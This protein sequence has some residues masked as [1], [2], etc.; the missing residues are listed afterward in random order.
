MFTPQPAAGRAA[1]SPHLTLPPPDP[2]RRR[3]PIPWL[4]SLAPVLGAFVLWQVTGYAGVLWFAL[5]GP[6]IAV[7]GVLDGSRAGRRAAREQQRVRAALALRIREEIDRRHAVERSEAS[8][9]TP[10]LDGYLDEPGELWRPH[11]SRGGLLVVG[12][13]DVVS[14]VRVNAADDELSRELITRA[15]TVSDAPVTVPLGA[16]IAV[17]GP[18]VIAAAVARGLV[19]QLCCT[20]P[21]GSLRVVT[22]AADAWVAALPHRAGSGVPCHL[23]LDAAQVRGREDAAVIV[24]EPHEPV[25]TRCA[26]VLTLDDIHRA[27]LEYAGRAVDVCVDVLSAAQAVRLASA[28]GERYRA[29]PGRR[30]LPSDVAARE[31]EHPT[32]GVGLAVAIGADGNGPAIVDLVADGPHALVAGMT[33]SGKSELLVTWVAQLAATRSTREVTFLL[34]DFKGGTAFD[35]LAELPHVAGVLTDLD[36][37]ATQRALESLRAEIRHRERALAA[38]GARDVADAGVEL[39]RLVVV[40]DEFAALLEAHRELGTLFADLAARGRALGIHLILGTQRAAGVV[41]ESLLANCPLRVSLRVVDD[42]DSRFV[43]GTH[44]AAEIPGELASRGTAFVRRAGDAE[45]HAL[46]VARTTPADVATIC[47]RRRAEPAPRRPWQPPLPQRWPLSEAPVSAERPVVGLVDEPDHQRQRAARLEKDDAGVLVLGGPGSGRT[48][49]LAAL[50]AQSPARW[51]PGDPEGLW[52]ALCELDGADDALVVVDDLDAALAGLPPDY[53][54]AALAMIERS[55]RSARAQGRRF[56][57]SSGRAMGPLA[58]IA[59]LLPRRVLLRM[60]SKIDHLGAG[61]APELFDAQAPAGRGALDGRPIQVPWVEA[62]LRVAAVEPP[63]Y[64]GGPGPVGVV[65]RDGMQARRVA[66]ALAD[67]GC[68]IVAMADVDRADPGAARAIV[69]DPEL[70]QRSW[71]VLQ[72]VRARGDLLVDAEC[73][74]EYRMLTGDRALPPFC[75]PGRGRAWLVREGALPVRVQLP[76]VD[77]ALARRIA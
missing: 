37:Y 26:A 29:L 57:I 46:R 62:P 33:G 20:H 47:D 14:D 59:D 69:A 17:R 40:V 53:A 34:A 41:R 28:L 43:I 5:L 13:G 35:A 54:A 58:R 23:D 71:P 11:P 24:V 72:M 50:A 21:P 60:P 8:R 63:L 38:A 66:A 64:A 4:A 77:P 19:L 75:A 2:P 7:A 36:P 76:G 73:A 70:W 65:I 39:P 44:A 45:P 67:R 31:L 56:A 25:P 30:E 49:A 15:G 52:D 27:R 9:A 42:A 12:H 18:R 51:L 32:A 10:T 61:G 48:T 1:A 3:P 6:V 68:D 74:A 55:C 22:E 16:G